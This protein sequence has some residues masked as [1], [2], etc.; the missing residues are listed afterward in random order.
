[1]SVVG[2]ITS[3]ATG[4]YTRTRRAVGTTSSGGDYT[5]GATSTATLTASVQPMPGTEL[6]HAPSGRHADDLRLVFT[7]TELRAAPIP[8]QITIDGEAWEVYR[9]RRW[10][11]FGDTH[12]EVHVSRLVLP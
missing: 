5:P 11:A 9:V 6:K 4:T 7:V 12:Y 1:M 10:Q 8:D 2:S 3:F